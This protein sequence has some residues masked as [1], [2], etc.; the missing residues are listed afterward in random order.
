M[1]GGLGEL[2]T[3]KSLS[4]VAAALGDETI[5]ALQGEADE[6]DAAI[7]EAMQLDERTQKDT[8]LRLKALGAHWHEAH[9]GGELTECPLCDEPLQDDALKAEID[10]LRRTGEAATRQLTDNLN[11]IEA[12]LNAA[13]PRALA[14]R[15]DDLAALAPRKS[16][17]ADIE[18]RF[19]NRLR[20]KKTLAAFTGLVADALARVPMAELEPLEPSTGQLDATQRLQA[21]IAAVR[22]L[23]LLEHWRRDYARRGRLGGPSGWRGVTRGG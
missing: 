19:V 21:R 8:R 4:T 16:L 13:V 1:S 14:S 22:R 9:R 18:T 7:A 20:F 2:P 15:L 3:W 6:A 12:R 5:A 17:I 10:T 11:A 23:V